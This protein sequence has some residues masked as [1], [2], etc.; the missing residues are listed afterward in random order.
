IVQ[1]CGIGLVR[2]RGKAGRLAFEAPPLRQSTPLEP[3]RLARIRLGLGL[4]D[5]EIVAA[6][7]LDGGLEQIALLIRSRE[8]LLALKPDWAK[9][10]E[11]GVGLVAPW[12]AGHPDFEVRVFD[13]TL[14]GSEDPVTGSFNA[15]AARWLIGAGLAPDHYVVSQGT[16]LGRAGRV[17]VDRDHDRIWIGG[18]ITDRITGLLAL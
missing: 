10:R 17:Y 5:D 2:L 13:S 8:R 7:L 16:V 18:D 4:A 1:E 3:D 12:G 15:S 14:T 11:D 9:L 6:R